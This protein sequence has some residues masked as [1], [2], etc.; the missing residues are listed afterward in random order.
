MRGKNRGQEGVWPGVQGQQKGGW[1]L[2]IVSR[3]A[4]KEEAGLRLV[5]GKRK[6]NKVC[7]IRNGTVVSYL[8]VP[9]Y[10]KYKCRVW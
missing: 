10:D 8:E 1:S 9:V 6:R 3:I 5:R 7:Y 2:L 4:R